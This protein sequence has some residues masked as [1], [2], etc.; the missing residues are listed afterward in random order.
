MRIIKLY[1][2]PMFDNP[3]RQIRFSVEV[4]RY[5][6]DVLRPSSITVNFAG[7]R[8]QRFLICLLARSIPWAQIKEEN[9]PT[10]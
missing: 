1:L 2:D 9:A 3:T 10:G 8:W 6:Q 7:T 4:W 5:G